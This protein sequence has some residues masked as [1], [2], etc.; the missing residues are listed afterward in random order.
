VLTP[1]HV[2]ALYDV[3]ADVH[4]HDETGHLT[5]VPIARIRRG[6]P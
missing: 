1:E 2:E 5:V 6:R 3:E 4:V